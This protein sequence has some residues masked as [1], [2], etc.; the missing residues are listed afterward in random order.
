MKN[1]KRVKIDLTANDNRVTV[2]DDDGEH[3][4]DVDDNIESIVINGNDVEVH[5]TIEA[6]VKTTG[7]AAA[8]TMTFLGLCLFFGW[9]LGEYIFRFGRE[10]AKWEV[11]RW[12]EMFG[13]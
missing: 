12:L 4:L 7:A 1:V 10:V 8:V 9:K 6:D 11:D 5:K 3:V 13:L 2:I